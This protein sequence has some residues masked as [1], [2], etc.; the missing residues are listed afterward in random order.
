MTEL[1]AAWA[2]REKD[3][4][5]II[6]GEISRYWNY[7]TATRWKARTASVIALFCYVLAPVTVVSSASNLSVFGM[8]AP[9]LAKLSLV[10]SVLFGFVE[11][12]RRIFG[13]DQRWVG[14]MM[15]MVSVKSQKERYLDSQIGKAIGSEEWKDNLLRTR[16]AVEAAATGEM[17][18]FFKNMLEGAEPK[19]RETP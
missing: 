11:G 10:L 2:G 13:F 19:A 7:S 14:A 17:S 9:D 12:V 5:E 15:A 6:D 8:L 16:A 1:E 3:L 4:M 18:D